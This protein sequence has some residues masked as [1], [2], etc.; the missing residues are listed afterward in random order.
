MRVMLPL[1]MVH[2]EIA[3]QRLLL[4]KIL[5][6]GDAIVHILEENAKLIMTK[7]QRNIKIK[8]QI[9]MNDVEAEKKYAHVIRR[10]TPVDLV[11]A[12]AVIHEVAA[13]ERQS[14]QQKG[15]AIR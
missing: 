4:Q 13:E 11:V 2:D 12:T 14:H 7:A 9:L 6:S 15:I 8:V 5:P 10:V 3:L 1:L